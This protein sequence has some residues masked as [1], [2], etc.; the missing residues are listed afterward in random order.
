MDN[1][2]DPEPVDPQTMDPKLVTYLRR[3]VTV[4]TTVMIVGL[5]VIV[6][7]FVTRFSD[8]AQPNLAL[9]EVIVL[10][11]GATPTAYT[12]G[13]GWYA[14]VTEDSEILIFDAKTGELIQEILVK[15][16]E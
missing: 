16:D 5:L 2:P 12:R 10:P 9:P 3:L 6:G 13:E 11:D 15:S 8:M 4:L 14:V 7:L 1:S